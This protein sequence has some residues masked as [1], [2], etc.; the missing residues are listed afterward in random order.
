[1]MEVGFTVIHEFEV[2]RINSLELLSRI[3]CLMLSNPYLNRSLSETEFDIS[4]NR[5]IEI[6]L[7][8]NAINPS[9]FDFWL[10]HGRF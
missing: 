1:M 8:A 6:I 3:A 9:R 4:A 2:L 10:W 7:V 5:L